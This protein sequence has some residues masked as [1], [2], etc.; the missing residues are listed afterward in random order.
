MEKVEVAADGCWNWQGALQANGY[1]AFVGRVA[2]RV[3]YE[4]LVGSV[5]DGYQLDHLCRNRSCVNPAHLEPVTPRENLSRSP[6]FQG[7]KTHCKH[8]HE[9]SP[10]NI[11]TPKGTNHRI[12]R[13]CRILRKR[14]WRLRQGS[15]PRKNRKV[16][17]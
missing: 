7:H 8:G 2:H 14:A 10:Q 13:T 12:C 3:A 17:A 1:G 11:F 6:H 4:V 5:P 15:V 9:F 16:V